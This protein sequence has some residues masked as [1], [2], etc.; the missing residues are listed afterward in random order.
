MVSSMPPKFSPSA[1]PGTK[2]SSRR[3]PE[4]DVVTLLGQFSLWL[5]TFAAGWGAAIA[6]FGRWQDRPELARTVVRS[7]YAVCAAL[8]VAA[9]CLWKGLLTHDFNIEYVAQYTS[10]NLPLPYV[11]SPPP[12]VR[13]RGAGPP[14]PAGSR[15]R[16]PPLLPPPPPV[17]SFRGGGGGRRGRSPPGP[18][19]KSRAKTYD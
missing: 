14:P 19:P 4:R 15:G 18:P 8:L 13:G 1:A 6:F 17:C 2:P 3:L 7:T 11:F 16:S 10:R 9:L 5:A 12:V